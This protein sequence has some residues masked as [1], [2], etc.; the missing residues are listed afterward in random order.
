MK[1]AKEVRQIADES[2]KSL[3]DQLSTVEKEII[4]AASRGAYALEL[5]NINPD[6]LGYLQNKLAESGYDFEYS[7]DGLYCKIVWSRA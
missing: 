7:A 5:L 1:K 3:D 6:F 2:L 4:K